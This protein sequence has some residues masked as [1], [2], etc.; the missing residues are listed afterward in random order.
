MQTFL[1]GL[2]V[3]QL[4]DL[5]IRAKAP[6][7]EPDSLVRE[8][9]SEQDSRFLIHVIVFFMLIY[10]W[11]RHHELYRHIT[12][13]NRGM[14]WINSA[15]LCCVCLV[16]F[17]TALVARSEFTAISLAVLF[18]TMAAAL[19]AQFALLRYAKR[20]SMTSDTGS[21]LFTIEL[22]VGV[23]AGIMT[24]TAAVAFLLSGFNVPG[25]A[26][27]AS[28]MVLALLVVRPLLSWYL[29]KH[30]TRQPPE[31]LA[32]PQNHKYRVKDQPL[33][34]LSTFFAGSSPDRSLLFTDSVYA[35]ALTL[36]SIQLVNT[37]GG[38]LSGDDVA[39]VVGATFTFDLRLGNFWTFLIIFAI[40]QVLWLQ[41]VR[42][43][44]FVETIR[45]HTQWLNSA[46]L[47]TVVMLP[48]LFGLVGAA[49]QDARIPWWLT[50]L[51]V[52]L[53]AGTLALLV[54]SCLVWQKVTTKASRNAAK[55]SWTEDVYLVYLA[56]VAIAPLGLI[57]LT[58][59]L[60]IFKDPIINAL[61][62]NP[63]KPRRT[64]RRVVMK[65]PNK[66]L[67]STLE[68]WALVVGG[69]FTVLCVVFAWRV[70]D[71]WLL[72]PS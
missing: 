33:G 26:W 67:G 63:S 10:L 1:A 3:E 25:S 7:D 29:T 13:L 64:L 20:S 39:N 44:L 56:L 42:I 22:F 36:M 8:W 32:V 23:P 54:A 35:I 14:L 11:R 52:I 46:H 65:N 72:T 40:V 16:P 51:G 49:P 15:F 59:L 50:S 43:F 24:V 70:Y 41:H 66:G 47:F 38:V 31:A 2:L 21:G 4:A 18:T 68:P 28:A 48:L 30:P 71:F 55:L 62:Y 37:Q 5:A 12:R 57:Y 6:T 69:I 19:W 53:C 60:L 61:W 9:I 27:Y 34:P 17:A 58:P 45:G